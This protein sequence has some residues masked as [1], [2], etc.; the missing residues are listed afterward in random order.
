MGTQEDPGPFLP[1]E[2]GRTEFLA[3]DPDRVPVITNAVDRDSSSYAERP[4]E[5]RT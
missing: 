4:A 1:N 5:D 2:E 3:P